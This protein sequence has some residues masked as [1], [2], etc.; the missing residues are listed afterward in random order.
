MGNAFHHLPIQSHPGGKQGRYFL[1]FSRE[2]HSSLR[3]DVL[4]TGWVSSHQK[5]SG[6]CYFKKVL[7]VQ[8]K[9]EPHQ[10]FPAIKWKSPSSLNTMKL[11]CLQRKAQKKG[12]PVLVSTMS[13][14]LSKE[15]NSFSRVDIQC[16]IYWLYREPVILNSEAYT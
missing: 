10:L 13:Q 16:K 14:M 15:T 1:L 8:V 3:R 7:Q 9:L 2:K 5:H 12:I 6:L 4:S 11:C